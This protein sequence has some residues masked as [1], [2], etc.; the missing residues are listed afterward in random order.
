[1]LTICMMV[2]NEA[3]RLLGSLG[4]VRSLASRIIV[5][6]TGSTDAT[7]DLARSL[8]AEVY[9][10]AMGE[11]FSEGRNVALAHAPEGWILFPD[12][13]EVIDQVS[14]KEIQRIARSSKLYAIQCISYTYLP[15][16]QWVQL[17]PI[18]M[19]RKQIGI[20]YQEPVFESVVQSIIARG[21]RIVP[22]T[23]VIHHSGYLDWQKR[24][25]KVRRYAAI[26][27]DMLTRS[28]YAK[29]I[30]FHFF[31]AIEYN[32]IGEFDK[33]PPIVAR[34]LAIPREFPERN[35]FLG[36]FYHTRGEYDLA[37]A[38]YDAQIVAGPPSAMA[39]NKSGLILSARGEYETARA[40]FEQAVRV[41]PHYAQHH[42]NLAWTL[43]MMGEEEAA[44]ATWRRAI[45]KNPRIAAMHFD[46]TQ[47]PHQYRHF[48]DVVAGSAPLNEL[49]NCLRV[50]NSTR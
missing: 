32:E 38:Y 5:V 21:G 27:A 17:T 23:I 33:G 22:S 31:L 10:H 45:K 29:N 2:R 48:P 12:A 37:L 14:Y 28:E 49:N 6:D 19:F 46:A 36:L 15:G 34:A 8:G 42:V 26:G 24:Q 13:D 1:M 3:Q 9:F 4:S 25:Q 44:L 30:L 11:N 20:Q 16:G 39:Y 18:R 35:R 40:R 43:C 7:V 47:L 41:Q 50:S